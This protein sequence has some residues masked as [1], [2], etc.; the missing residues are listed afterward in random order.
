[1]QQPN[2]TNNLLADDSINFRQTLK[3]V[4]SD[5]LRKG[6]ESN[7]KKRKLVGKTKLIRMKTVI[8]LKKNNK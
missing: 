3:V 7:D 6:E 5:G 4:A 1:M 2:V 8:M